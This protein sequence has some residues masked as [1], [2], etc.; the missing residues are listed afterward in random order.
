MMINTPHS[1]PQQQDDCE[2]RIVEVS[3]ID[4]CATPYCAAQEALLRVGAALLMAPDLRMLRL[5]APSSQVGSVVGKGGVRINTMRKETDT[6]IKV[7]VPDEERPPLAD[8][9]DQVVVIE[10]SP[11]PMLHALKAVSGA[12]REGQARA[13]HRKI[14]TSGG[15]VYGIAAAGMYTGGHPGM[16]PGYMMPMPGAPQ[17]SYSGGVP[18]G[19]MHTDANG[20][21]S[22]RI[23]ISRDQVGMGRAQGMCARV[24]TQHVFCI[25]ALQVGAVLGPRGS[26]IQQVRSISGAKVKLHDTEGPAGGREL[27]IS[28]SLEQM[29]TAHSMVHNF[30]QAAS[31]N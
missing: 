8:E 15:G 18:G 3:S 27:E 14:V 13:Q 28:G 30:L 29:Q 31:A 20:G 21:T 6:R 25:H 1:T 4:D 9:D 26:N 10:G 24:C 19:N 7:G 17:R 22:M 11:V 5:L 2:D 12:L 23:T 16:G